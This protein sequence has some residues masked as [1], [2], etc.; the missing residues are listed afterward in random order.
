MAK[1]G[2]AT[3]DFVRQTEQAFDNLG[4]V[5]T[6]GQSWVEDLDLRHSS[7]VA[8]LASGVLPGAGQAYNDQW[9]K[10]FVFF[11]GFAL[12]AGNA[13]GLG[14]LGGGPDWGGMALGGPGSGLMGGALLWGWSI[15]DAA[16]QVDEHE[17]FARPVT[18]MVVGFANG[19]TGI[20]EVSSAGFTADWVMEPGFS[21][22][23]DRTGWVVRPG[24]A[25]EFT[26]GARMMVGGEGRRFRPGA[27]V[28]AG[29]ATGEV[30]EQDGFVRALVGAGANLRW[31]A[32]P[33]YYLELEYRGE[34][35][36][37]D[38]HGVTALGL[39]VHLG[40]GPGG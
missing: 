18:G 40:K 13:F 7:V 3:P 26:T 6:V 30:P 35:E 10:G 34:L 32:T 14:V 23:L 20:E 24:G 22:G 29:L 33:R 9:V 4:E 38:V 17:T 11:S 5:A 2:A 8:G 39:G 31:Y 19:W 15:A 12:S 37:E 21:L 1:G 28:A 25:V 16:Y 27:F 36:G